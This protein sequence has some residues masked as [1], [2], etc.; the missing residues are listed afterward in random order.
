M[1][2]VKCSTNILNFVN[3]PD[4]IPESNSMTIIIVDVLHYYG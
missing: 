4:I 1:N 3:M 2:N